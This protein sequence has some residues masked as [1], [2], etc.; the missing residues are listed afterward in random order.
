MVLIG[1]YPVSLLIRMANE[2]VEKFAW[3]AKVCSTENSPDWKTLEVCDSRISREYLGIEVKPL[4]QKVFSD[5]R[6]HLD[7]LR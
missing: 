5:M 1:L 2:V 3:A 4:N 6:H 7:L